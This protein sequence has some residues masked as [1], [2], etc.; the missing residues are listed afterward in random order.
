MPN[1]PE[2]YQKALQSLSLP[3]KV[4]LHG[5]DWDNVK[6]EPPYFPEDQEYLIQ[7]SR[8]INWIRRGGYKEFFSE[9]PQEAPLEDRGITQKEA[10]VLMCCHV[11]TVSRYLK[12]GLLLEYGNSIRRKVSFNSVMQFLSKSNREKP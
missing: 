12:M 9:E 8:S 3:K 4:I 6:E 7:L 5:L 11:K 10:A 1:T 2:Q